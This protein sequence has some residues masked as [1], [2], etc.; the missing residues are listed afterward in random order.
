MKESLG[1]CSFNS[2][3]LLLLLLLLCH[4]LFVSSGHFCAFM[5]P[6]HT[7]DKQLHD[8]DSQ[9]RW[10]RHATIRHSSTWV[11]AAKQQRH[12]AGGEAWVLQADPRLCS[13]R[14]DQLAQQLTTSPVSCVHKWE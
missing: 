7:P 2:W 12:E 10:R 9:G 4:S 11:G 3:I 8:A 14:I 1:C 13:I 5:P 6:P